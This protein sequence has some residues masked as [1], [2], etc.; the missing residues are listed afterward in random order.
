M[1]PRGY[2]LELTTP[3][4]NELKIKSVHFKITYNYLRFKHLKRTF[5][6]LTGQW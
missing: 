5:C 2:S 4:S 3:Y 6:F 1:S